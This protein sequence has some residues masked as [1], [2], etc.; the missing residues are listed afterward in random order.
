MKTRINGHELAWELTGNGTET[1]AYLNGIG[2]SI[3]HWSPVAAQIG[4]YRSLCH[5]FFGQLKSEKGDGPYTLQRHARDL[6]ELMDAA[7]VES[8]HIVGTSYGSE[9]GMVFA[10]EFPDRCD[11]LMVIDGVSEL[12][13]VLRAAVECWKASALADPRVFYRSLIPWTYG[14]SYLKAN[15]DALLQREDL[16]AALPREYFTSF[17]M[18]CD[19][20]LEIDITPVLKTISCPTTVVV[21]DGDILKHRLFADII[22]R[23]I[24][25]SRLEVV[26]DAGHGVV[27]EKPGEIARLIR[28]HLAR[29]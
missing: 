28:E 9:V 24:P 23:E 8:A 3:A 21:A 14:N 7:Q 19:A 26:E 20:F 12:D 22:N 25:H 16:I 27:I 1:V 2:M 15:R 4:D 13:P 18:L 29:C 10:A 6:A 17:A 11:S 5:D